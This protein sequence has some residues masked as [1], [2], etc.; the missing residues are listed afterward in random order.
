MERL[1]ELANNTDDLSHLTEA[2]KC[3]ISII[4]TA[5]LSLTTAQALLAAMRQ[6]NHGG[7][8]V[9][10]AEATIAAINA[11]L[12]EARQAN[13]NTARQLVSKH[14]KTLNLLATL[15]ASSGEAINALVAIHPNVVPY[16]VLAIVPAPNVPPNPIRPLPTP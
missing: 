13:E 4:A 9:G 10:I 2:K 12:M 1:T 15:Q 7:A 14:N 6:A 3:N 5:E 16:G 8:I 11:T